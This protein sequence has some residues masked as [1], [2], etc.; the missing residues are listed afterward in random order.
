MIKSSVVLPALVL[1]GL[2]YNILLGVNWMVY[3]K[4]NL[5]LK[6]MTLKKEGED[7]KISAYLKPMTEFS[8]GK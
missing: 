1:D 7:I 5:D 2:D 6:T 8:E 4:V 3:T